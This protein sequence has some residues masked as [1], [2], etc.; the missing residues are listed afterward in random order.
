MLAAGREASRARQVDSRRRGGHIPGLGHP[1][2]SR[3]HLEG[4][5]E[6]LELESG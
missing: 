6:F 5:R 2:G 1:G 3:A 4:G